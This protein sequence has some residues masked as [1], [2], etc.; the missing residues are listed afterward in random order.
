MRVIIIQNHLN[1][2]R[3]CALLLM[4]PGSTLET[5][6]SI[7]MFVE[8]LAGSIETE[9][10]FYI[11]NHLHNRR[12]CEILLMIPGSTLETMKS[13]RMFVEHLASSIETEED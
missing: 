3:V 2:R 7:Q 1:T 4:I 6:K 8:Q 13:I 5:M 9:E 11:Q 12:V 10:G